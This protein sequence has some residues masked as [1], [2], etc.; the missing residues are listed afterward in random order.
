VPDLICLGK[1]LG[2][3]L[4]LSAC[5][6]L[7]RSWTPGP[8]LRRGAS[9]LH[10]PGAPPGLRFGP[11]LPGGPGGGGAPGRA[12]K[13]GRGLRGAR[14]Q[15]LEGV[16][17][18]GVCGGGVPSSGWSWTAGG[19]SGDGVR[20]AEA[21]LRR[22]VI[23]LPPATGA[24]WWSWLPPGPGQKSP[25]GRRRWTL[26]SGGRPGGGGAPGARLDGDL[27]SAVHVDHVPGD[28]VGLRGGQGHRGR[29]HVLGVV[30]RPEGF[31]AFARP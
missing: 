3:G 20:V 16:E 2:G 27:L 17:G 19:A 25:G 15:A 1:A 23:L 11:R 21:A 28:P 26:L 7:Q 22:G 30:R 8:L 29:R 13:L 9:H 24:R 31:L 14:R 4:P 6:G 18:S 10:L 5:V 12:L